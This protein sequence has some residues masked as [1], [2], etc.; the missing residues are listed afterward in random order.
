[1]SWYTFLIFHSSEKCVWL[2]LFPWFDAKTDLELNILIEL[3]SFFGIF[4]I[5]TVWNL[6]WTK[7]IKKG[8][9]TVPNHKK[10]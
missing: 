1:M 8:M 3:V 6:F 7:K 9:Q 5:L 4:L 2:K 10:R